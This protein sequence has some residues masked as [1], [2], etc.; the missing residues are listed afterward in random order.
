MLRNFMAM[1]E[2]THDQRYQVFRYLLNKS[3]LLGFKREKKNKITIEF[4][5]TLVQQMLLNILLL[6]L[7]KVTQK[8]FYGK[9]F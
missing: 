7:I 6:L 5:L 3:S 4:L 8:T 9:L 1:G 2:Y